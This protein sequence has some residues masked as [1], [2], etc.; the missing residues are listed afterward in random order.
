MDSTLPHL[1][2]SRE[3]LL[4]AYWTRACHARR[5]AAFVTGQRILSLLRGHSHHSTA[6]YHAVF[7]YVSTVKASDVGLGTGT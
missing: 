4:D 6:R 1:K 2:D 5:A 7:T 3:R